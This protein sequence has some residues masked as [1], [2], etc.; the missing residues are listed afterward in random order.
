MSQ[1]EKNRIY[2]LMMKDRQEYLQEG[3]KAVAI[4]LTA[5]AAACV[6]PSPSTADQFLVLLRSELDRT[7]RLGPDHL[8]RL[9][10]NWL[11]RLRDAFFDG[12]V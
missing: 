12:N 9:P 11:A 3:A 4:G 8:A 10:S 2:E 6:A 5:Y 7:G 1:E